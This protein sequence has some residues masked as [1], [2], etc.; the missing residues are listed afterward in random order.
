MIGRRASESNVIKGEGPPKGSF[1]P[2]HYDGHRNEIVL[3][4]DAARRSTIR[5]ATKII[6]RVRLNLWVSFDWFL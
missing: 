2:Y 4:N 5:K 6:F 3:K 1:G